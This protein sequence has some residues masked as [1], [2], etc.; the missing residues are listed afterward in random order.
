MIFDEIKLMEYI[1]KFNLSKQMK[2]ISSPFNTGGFILIIFILFVYN[3][4]TLKEVVLIFIACNMAMGLKLIFK[5][6]RPYHFS[7][8]II[9]YSHKEHLTTTNKYSFPSGHTFSATIISL[10]MLS[11]FPREYIF[12]IL[13]ILVG[14]SRIFLGVHYPSDIIG[15]ILF[16]FIFFRII[17]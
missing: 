11:K 5:R 15:G 16:G 1:Q 3:I 12:N 4:I 10:L 2:L 9:N 13:A 6:K 14:F 8:T 17:F 7:N